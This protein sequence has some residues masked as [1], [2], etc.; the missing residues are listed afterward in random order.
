MYLGAAECLSRQRKTVTIF[1]CF[2]IFIRWCLKKKKK[3]RHYFHETHLEHFSALLVGHLGIK[4]NEI[5]ILLS[6]LQRIFVIFTLN[7][8]KK[9]LFITHWRIYLVHIELKVMLLDKNDIGDGAKNKCVKIIWKLKKVIFE[10]RCKGNFSPWHE[11]RILK[12]YFQFR[13]LC[14]FIFKSHSTKKSSIFKPSHFSTN[15]FK[16]DGN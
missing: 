3:S 5:Q 1:S 2:V 14:P 13:H 4:Q 7:C 15:C 6:F 10:K 12:N 16:I 11:L 8:F 9:F